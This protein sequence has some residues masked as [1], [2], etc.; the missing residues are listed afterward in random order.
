M[1]AIIKRR[2]EDANAR[3]EFDAIYDLYLHA[4]GMAPSGE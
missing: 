2:K 4:L 3:E 1:K